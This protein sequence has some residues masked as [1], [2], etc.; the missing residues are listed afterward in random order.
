MWG[1]N[2]QPPLWGLRVVWLGVVWGNHL[3][4]GFP[5]C[6]LTFVRDVW[7][8]LGQARFIAVLSFLWGLPLGSLA[9]SFLARS[10]DMGVAPPL[11]G[12]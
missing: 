8:G 1:Y 2:E 4:G 5:V 7:K 10:V 11:Y 9:R 3:V 12:N 6:S